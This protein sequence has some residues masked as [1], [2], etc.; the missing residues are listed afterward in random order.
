MP[1]PAPD[2]SLPAG[3]AFEL[4]IYSDAY[5]RLA[6]LTE[7]AGGRP[8]DDGFIEQL[9]STDGY[10][11]ERRFRSQFR[12][13]GTDYVSVRVQTAAGPAMTYVRLA[14]ATDRA[15]S[16]VCRWRSRGGL[17]EG[18][19]QLAQ[20]C[21][22]QLSKPITSANYYRLSGTFDPATG[23]IFINGTFSILADAPTARIE[24][25]LNRRLWLYNMF[26][27]QACSVEIDRSKQG[28][29]DA[30]VQRI[31]VTPV[32]PLAMNDRLGLSFHYAGSLG[33]SDGVE[34]PSLSLKRDMWLPLWPAEPLIIGDVALELPEGMG[35][36]QPGRVASDERPTTW[37]I[38]SSAPMPSELRFTRRSTQSVR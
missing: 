30:G 29:E 5:P 37:L 13:G 35:M 16:L 17:D 28:G 38:G 24:L 22:D 2:T 26:C 23:R 27:N 32:R 10:G 31:V 15:A 12:V 7:R 21:F 14:R 4:A 18:D 8:A 20:W 34:M 11:D 1:W 36:L 19:G 6:Q 25:L 33:L 3:E 9:V